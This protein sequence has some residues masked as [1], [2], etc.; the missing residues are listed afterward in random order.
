MKKIHIYII[1]SAICLLFIIG[2]YYYFSASSKKNIKDG[3]EP[4]SAFPTM[5]P[6]TEEPTVEP[7]LTQEQ[8]DQLEADKEFGQ[9]T[10]DLYD[11]YPWYDNLPLQTE[12]YFVYFDI[13]QKKFIADIYVASEQDAIKN[14]IQSQLKDMGIDTV[15]YE[16]AWVIK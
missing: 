5:I 2:A 13:Y 4:T 9:W 1:I 3:I 16:I 12:K 6:S 10:K 7:T 14:E 15:V 8:L 11:A